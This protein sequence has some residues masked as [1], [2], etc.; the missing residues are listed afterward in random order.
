MVDFADYSAKTWRRV[1]YPEDVLRRAKKLKVIRGAMASF[2]WHPTLLDRF[3]PYYE[4]VPGSFEKIG[5]TKTLTKIVDGLR[6]MGY[7]FKSIADCDLF[8]SRTC[9]KGNEI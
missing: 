4:E 2:F 7:E 9:K 8:P 6:E 1:S 3:M 5:G